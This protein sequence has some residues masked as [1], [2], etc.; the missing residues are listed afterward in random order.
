MPRGAQHKKSVMCLVDKIHALE[1]LSL[2]MDYNGVGREFNV[3]ES[4]AYIK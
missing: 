1:K 4:I 2:V 3:N